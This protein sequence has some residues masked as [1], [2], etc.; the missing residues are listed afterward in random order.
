MIKI[1]IPATSANLGPGFDTLAIAWK[2]FL[3]I[4]IDPSYYGKE[5][6]YNTKSQQ[7][8]EE[9]NLFLKALNRTLELI[10]YS[11]KNYLIELDSEIPIGKGLGSSATVIWGGI[12]SAE[13]LA[14]KELSM[15]DRFKIAYSLENHLDNLSAS[16][17][18]GLTI[19]TM[20]NNNPKIVKFPYPDE[21]CG[22]IYIPPYSLPTEKARKLLPKL[23][24]RDKVVYNLQSLAFL[25][26]GFLYK[27][28][29]LLT[30]GIRDSIHQ[31]YRFPLIS[32]V[33]IIKKKIND[34]GGIGI[35][36]SGAGPSLLTF[37][38]KEK[39]IKIKSGLEEFIKKE[40]LKGEVL[41]LEI[42]KE[43]IIIEK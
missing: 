31:P 2:L 38:L 16:Y 3:H 18:G 22:V 11:P 27:D 43:G 10:G 37:A 26:S 30:L 32:E 20:E 28:E 9:D 15:H 33:N 41:L 19:C 35:V 5:I 1:K 25:L 34:L 21:L 6:I 12:F 17:F 42:C 36:L 14:K 4:K 8:K 40:G 39:A 23:Y 13:I 7:I 29:N 24:E